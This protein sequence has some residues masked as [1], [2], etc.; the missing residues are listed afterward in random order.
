MKKI[1]Q[2]KLKILAKL[3]LKKYKPKIIGVTGSVGKTS[4]KE[5]IYAVLA[6]KFKVRQSIKNYNNEIGLPL[7]IIGSDSPGKSIFGWWGVMI[8]GIYLLLRK[9]ENYPEMLVLEMGVDRPGD[10]AYLMK[11]TK[12][13][14]GVITMIANSHLEYF[15]SIKEIQKEKGL[16]IEKIKPD[17]WAILNFDN[18]LTKELAGK[19]RAKTLTYGFKD[20]AGVRAQELSF[21]FF[22]TKDINNLQGLSFKLTHAG[23]FVPMA[24]PKVIGYNSVYAALAAAAVGISYD[25]NLV[26]IAKAL[27]DLASPPGRMNLIP[28][29]KQTLIIDDTYNSSPQS[30]ISALD[31]LSKIKLPASSRK[32]AVLGDMLELGQDTESGHREVGQAVFKVGVDKLIVVGERARDIARG[33]QEAGMDRDDIFQFKNSDEAKMF[34]QNRLQQGDLALIKGSQGLRMEKIVKEIMAEPLRAKELLVRQ[35]GTWNA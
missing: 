30:S 19:S 31:I 24:L 34:L 21:S 35:D 16:M 4:T 10:M 14:I 7:T 33:A 3:I 11:I 26:D 28:G 17:G 12:A 18:D 15:K 29:I 27:K 6:S 8:K 25:I 5:A 32:F 1:I 2:F 9:D 20:G 13:D 23:S 22:N